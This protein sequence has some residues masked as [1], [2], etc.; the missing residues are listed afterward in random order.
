MPKIKYK[1]DI[2]NSK[3][4]LMVYLSPNSPLFDNSRE[5]NFRKFYSKI[6]GIP[7]ARDSYE[8]LRL[9][10]HGFAS[11]GEINAAMIYDNMDKR[12]DKSYI[13]KIKSDGSELG[14]QQAV[15]LKESN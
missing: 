14:G 2:P 9:V 8:K 1:P 10:A 4:L 3:Y 13:L 7:E 6:L 12:Q 5:K 15:D 11:K